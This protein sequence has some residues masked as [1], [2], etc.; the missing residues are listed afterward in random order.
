MSDKLTTEMADI[1]RFK[2][3]AVLLDI[4]CRSTGVGFA[5]V[6]RVTE[7]RWIA[8][9]ARNDFGFELPPNG[10]LDIKST[11]CS[12]IR[13]S[14]QKIVIEDVA[15]DTRFSRHPAPARHGFK[16]YI[17]VPIL[18]EDGGFFGTLCAFDPA[19]R[20][21][22][23][24]ETI[25][26]FETFATLIGAHLSAIDRERKAQDSLL[27]ERQTSA[28]LERFIAVLGH[29]LRNPLTA[30]LGGMEMLRKNPLNDRATQWVEMVVTSAGRMAVLIELVMDFSRSSLGGG[31]AVECL[32]SDFVEPVLEQ[33]V[34]DRRIASP[35]RIIQSRF[36]I[37]EPVN[38][39]LRRIA[40][41]AS[42]LL[43]NAINHGDPERPVEVEARTTDGC[44][45]MTVANAGEP[46]PE[47][48]LAR[49]FEP[50]S[51]GTVQ[52]SREGMGLGLYIANQI[53]LAH[54][55]SLEVRSIQDETRFTFRMPLERAQG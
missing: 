45:E 6:A 2:A 19:P 38:C 11:L 20:P 34:A 25:A 53:A 10:E 26:M 17:S 8:C 18:R 4:I 5:A 30:I 32:P 52:P 39:D 22:N 21:L 27:L 40:Q 42:N 44:F 23:A 12:D 36:A 13:R 3:I 14:R 51:R 1:A 46:I 31:V 29:D 41:L 35:G 49:I 16:S 48:V 47:T 24:P 7:E 15:L 37:N 43:S 55:G 50:F 33:L 28:L 9:A 54:S